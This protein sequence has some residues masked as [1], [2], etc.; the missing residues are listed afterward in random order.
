MEWLWS[1]NSPKKLTKLFDLELAELQSVKDTL[2]YFKILAKSKSDQLHDDF[3]NVYNYYLDNCKR[4]DSRI[5]PMVH[6]YE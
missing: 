4:Y 1:S 5:R 6:V 2:S 3:S